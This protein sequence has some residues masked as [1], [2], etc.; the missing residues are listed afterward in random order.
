MK[1]PT[2]KGKEVRG[3]LASTDRYLE[4]YYYEAAS[5]EEEGMIAF[6]KGESLKDNPYISGSP[7]YWKWQRGF[8]SVIED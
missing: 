5:P 4:A 2:R 3:P 1:Y 8:I 6:E 7:A